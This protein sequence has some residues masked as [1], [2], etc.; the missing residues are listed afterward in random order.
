MGI[1]PFSLKPNYWNDF[2]VLAEDIEFLYNH[3]LEIETPLPPDELVKVLVKE[4]IRKEKSALENQQTSSG[5]V[6]LP[7]EKYE[8]GQNIL[9]PAL[10]WK[11]GQ[12]QSVRP[13]SN[14]ELS[15][16]DVIE[17]SFENGEKRSFA[18][19]LEKHTLNQPVKINLDDPQLVVD[20]VL[21]THGVHITQCLSEELDSN[22]DLVR[23][24]GRWFPRALLVDINI[25]H[26]NLVEA[27]L[28]M[29]G[30][31]PL[32][33]QDLMEQIDLPKDVNA[34]L[35]EFSLNL[36]LQEDTRFDEVGP[37][38][39]ILW[40]LLRLEPEPVQQP[41]IYLRY[42]PTDIDNGEVAAKLLSQFEGY[43]ADE[44]EGCEGPKE[45]SDKI[46]VS[47][48]YPH[49]R[50]GTLP[51]C[52]QMYRLFP[53]AIETPR[54]QFTFVDGDT[55][56]KFEGWVV[57][58][59]KYAYGLREWYAKNEL[60]P[61]SVITIQRG[62]NP[63]EVVIRANRKRPARDWVR[64]A[65]IGSDGGVIFALL[66]HSLSTTLNER[67]AIVISDNQVLDQLWEQGNKQRASLS[68]IVKT[69]M[70]EIGK[71][72]PQGHIHAQELYAAINVIR[73]C[74]PGPILNTLLE[75]PWAVYL[76]DLYFRL[77]ETAEEG[78]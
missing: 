57:R 15:T 61:G 9:F 49:L 58:P 75:N 66:K 43:L 55:G 7:E 34:K 28:E 5:K 45:F 39:K 59:Y 21:K 67:M 22:P 10:D 6:Y 71:L 4:R 17:V 8:V 13:G 19:S 50:A 37:A 32:K 18:S 74:P 54:V 40:Y 44:L 78:R 24:A 68:Y 53:T 20:K 33:T 56:Q 35:N 29:E 3:L 48:I 31:G 47:L 60:I 26:L 14:P 70:R 23:I 46:S 2:E 63:E 72:S 65:M 73:R 69:T 1:A 12:V 52:D 77:D 76:G 51:V 64:T 25:G 41:P 36:A 38:G 27:V 16:F 11:K 62:V 42:A 30:G